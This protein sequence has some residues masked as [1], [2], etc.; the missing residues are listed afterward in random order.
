MIDDNL[1]KFWK[2]LSDFHSGIV[3]QTAVNIKI[4]TSL[5]WFQRNKKPS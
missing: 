3:D 4:E 5:G 2:D 1:L